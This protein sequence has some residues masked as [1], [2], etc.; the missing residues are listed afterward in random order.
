MLPQ[1]GQK[2]QNLNEA[3]SFDSFSLPCHNK[4]LDS[5]NTLIESAIS[6]THFFHGY[7][8]FLFV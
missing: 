4:E 2:A 7:V 3:F 6:I 5:Y 1:A 8:P